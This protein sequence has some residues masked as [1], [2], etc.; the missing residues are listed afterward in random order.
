MKKIKSKKTSI[1][2]AKMNFITQN[3]SN[4]HLEIQFREAYF[5]N[6]INWLRIAIL[7]SIFLYAGFGLLDKTT[8]PDFT[9][10]FFIVRYYIVIP[11]LLG[12][13]GLTFLKNFKKIWQSLVSVTLIVAGSGII[14]MLHRNP[15]NLYYYGGLFMIFMGG[16]FYVKLRF[17]HATISGVTLVIIYTI[18]YFLIPHD[19]NSTSNNLIIADAFFI[20]SNIICMIGLYSIEKLERTDFYQQN[21]LTK[22]QE[23]IKQINASLEEKVLNRTAELNIA[24]EKA[25]ESDRLKTEFLASMS[26]EI[27]TPLNVI[28]GFSQIIANANTD[29]RFD[30]YSKTIINQTDLL[31]K[32]INDIID[33]AK[34]ESNSIL[35]VADTVNLHDLLEELYLQ[36]QMNLPAKIQLKVVQPD[37]NLLIFCNKLRLHQVMSNLLLNA[38]KF[39]KAGKI[40]FGAHILP[41][42]EI[43]FYVEDT[44]VGIPKE[45]QQLIFDKFYKGDSYAQGAGLG[46]GI[47]KNIVALMGGELT[48]KSEQGKGSLFSYTLP[49]HLAE[50]DISRMPASDANRD[51]NPFPTILIAEDTESNK[52]LLQEIL[53]EKDCTLIF[54]TNGAEAVEACRNNKNISLILMD[55][56]MPIM[57][58]IEATKQIRLKDQ[59]I[60]IIAVTAYAFSEDRIRAIDA[61][62]NEIITKPLIKEEILQLVTDFM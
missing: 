52:I 9:N 36:F 41:T 35:L 29:F 11:V 44:G 24:K 33:V 26:H 39:T 4:T 50:K 58:G 19:V 48:V 38:I 27:R 3:F 54:A 2:V 32:L 40:E 10:E 49:C 56:K 57:N 30:Q 28:V 22:K 59:E 6:S 15:T 17:I 18:S 25:E 5:K 61:G 46:L 7:T 1:S 37:K 20:A 31:L 51:T 45:E 43:Q 53:R 55:L 34:I 12:L 16:Y 14:Y 42:K 60:P 23:E 8:S 47:A 21:L 62:C 13:I